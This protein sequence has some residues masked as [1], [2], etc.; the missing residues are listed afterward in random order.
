MC[1]PEGAD[2]GECETC[3]PVEPA[4]GR[5]WICQKTSWK[6]TLPTISEI[7]VL[8]GSIMWEA[9]YFDV[10]PKDEETQ[11]IPFEEMLKKLKPGCPL[12]FVRKSEY[13]PFFLFGNKRIEH[14][15][16]FGGWRKGDPF[17]I[18]R[19][20]IPAEVP[21]E[22]KTKSVPWYRRF[23]PY[24]YVGN[25]AEIRV[26]SFYD[27]LQLNNLHCVKIGL[28]SKFVD[29]NRCRTLTYER[30]CLDIGLK[31][32]DLVY[33]NCETFVRN[34]TCQTLK[35]SYQS[36]NMV[37]LSSGLLVHMLYITASV[38][39]LGFTYWMTVP[40][41]LCHTVSLIAAFATKNTIV[42]ISLFVA[43]VSMFIGNLIFYKLLFIGITMLHIGFVIIVYT[44]FN[45]MIIPIVQDES[46]E[47]KEI[48]IDFGKRVSLN[49]LRK[50]RI[51]LEKKLLNKNKELKNPDMAKRIELK[52]TS[53]QQKAVVITLTILENWKLFSLSKLADSS[54]SVADKIAPDFVHRCQRG[55]KLILDIVNDDTLKLPE[56]FFRQFAIEMDSLKHCVDEVKRKTSFNFKVIHW[57]T[58][59]QFTIY[60]IQKK[61]QGFLI[62]MFCKS[63]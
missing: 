33:D 5:Q 27:V 57:Y 47:F 18:H 36:N 9:K 2:V 40:L 22:N 14:W 19:Y 30:A 26:D 20:G 24:Q 16:I 41:A 15:A 63:Y 48:A 53:D 35:F 3:Y 38:Y 34:S 58:E 10:Y 12:I 51:V 8:V 43:V 49:K 23:S 42:S 11:S 52:L 6:C 32:Y 44:V 31:G 62:S 39:C 7:F 56:N 54:I 21:A 61:I 37:F 17:V 25:K 50:T 59:M 1:V 46:S 55:L 29:D 45:R 60:D 28:C 4:Q 13:K